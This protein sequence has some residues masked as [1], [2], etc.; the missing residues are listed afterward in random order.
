M[1][2]RENVSLIPEIPSN[3]RVSVSMDLKEESARSVSRLFVF[4]L[5][6]DNRRS[7]S[8]DIDECASNPCLNDGMCADGVNGFMCE[9]EDGFMGDFCETDIDECESDPCLNGATCVDK[10]NA[11]ECQCADGFEGETCEISK[12]LKTAA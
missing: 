12:E 2:T 11:F 5:R 4:F 1:K 6:S 7:T 8:L 9:C 10:R 3:S